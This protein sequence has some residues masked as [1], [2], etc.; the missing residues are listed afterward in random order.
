MSQSVK[1]KIQLSLLISIYIYARIKHMNNCFSVNIR[2]KTNSYFK[3][4]S[5]EMLFQ[6]EL[7]T[8]TKFKICRFV[9]LVY[10]K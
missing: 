4:V 7:L 5:M 1:R 6:L 3:E 8:M 10:L 9:V 2:V